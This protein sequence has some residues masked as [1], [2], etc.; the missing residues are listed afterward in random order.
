[1]YKYVNTTC[2]VCECLVLPCI[3]NFR[4]GHFVLDNQIGEDYLF[5]SQ[6][7]LVACSS[8]FMTGAL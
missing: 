8:L 7:S 3:N 2:S 6:Y 1:M 5:H 4:A